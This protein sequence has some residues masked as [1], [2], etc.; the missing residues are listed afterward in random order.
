MEEQTLAAQLEVKQSGARY[1]LALEAEAKIKLLKL[2]AEAADIAAQHLK[3]ELRVKAEREEIERKAAVF[4]AQRDKKAADIAEIERVRKANEYRAEQIYNQQ[5]QIAAEQKKASDLIRKNTEDAFNLEQENARALR[6]LQQKSRAIPERPHFATG[7]IEAVQSD[8]LEAAV[9]GNEAADPGSWGNPLLRN[10]I[11][12][13][14]SAV[15]TEQVPV[16]VPQTVPIENE[17]VLRLK[18]TYGDAAYELSAQFVRESPVPKPGTTTEQEIE[19]H[20]R[21]TARPL[22][23]A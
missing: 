14:P 13:R 11:F 5:A 16:N 18:R 12:S 2:Q 8:G 7:P 23:Q 21:T 10:L 6:E 3:E 1:A 20:L 4:Q 22:V 19:A 17:N 15:A 9:Q